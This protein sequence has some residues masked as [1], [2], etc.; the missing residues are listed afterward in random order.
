MM[1][2]WPITMLKDIAAMPKY[3]V[4]WSCFAPVYADRFIEADSLE[5][6]QEFAHTTKPSDEEFALNP[7]NVDERDITVL[8][9]E[10]V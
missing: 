9:V 7:D 1:K 3:H 10:A 5:A 6:A 4:I 2:P 8:D